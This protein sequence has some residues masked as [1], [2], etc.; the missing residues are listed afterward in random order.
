MMTNTACNTAYRGP[1]RKAPCSRCGIRVHER[2]PAVEKDCL[3]TWEVAGFVVVQ[4]RHTRCP[5]HGDCL[6]VEYYGSYEDREY[7][8]TIYSKTCPKREC[9]PK[10][11]Q[12]TD[13]HRNKILNTY[14]RY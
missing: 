14:N 7:I 13:E 10:A 1:C 6:C 5:D 3:C 11:Q 12:Q 9:I 2:M 8:G 4:T